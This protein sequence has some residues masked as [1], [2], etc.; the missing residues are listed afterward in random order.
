M[1]KANRMVDRVTES[2]DDTHFSH[3]IDGRAK[4]NFLKKV[5][6]KML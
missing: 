2:F 1:M 3:R 5:G 4:N 6:R